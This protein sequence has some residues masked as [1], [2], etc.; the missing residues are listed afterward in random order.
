MHD[1]WTI[2]RRIQLLSD[3]YWYSL[4]FAGQL[5]FYVT[6][7][8]FLGGAGTVFVAVCRLD[9]DRSREQALANLQYW[10]RFIA[11]C[12]GAAGGMAPAVAV[13]ANVGEG[14]D[15]VATQAWLDGLQ[16]MLR[17]TF[18]SALRLAD[19]AVALDCR[20]H[21]G[22]GSARLRELLKACLFCT[23]RGF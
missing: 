7:E 10:L 16:P 14:A 18:G 6:H 4:T 20:N 21:K 9:R 23:A 1:C 8:M 17:R 12:S 19:A 22:A 5:E 2:L 3:R 13:V 11:S 15:A